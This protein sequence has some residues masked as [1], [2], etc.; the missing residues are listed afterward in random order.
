MR[1]PSDSLTFV[2]LLASALL[3]E[4]GGLGVEAH[5]VTWTPIIDDLDGGPGG[6]CSVCPCELIPEYGEEKN[7]AIT[8]I[9]PYGGSLYLGTYNWD[10]GAEIWRWN[11]GGSFEPVMTG[12]WGK[13]YNQFLHSMIEFEGDLYAGTW[14]DVPSLFPQPERGMSLWRYDGVDWEAVTEDGFGDFENDAA[15]SLTVFQGALYAGAYNP[16]DGPEVWR[17]LDGLAWEP[18]VADQVDADSEGPDENGFCCPMNSDATVVGVFNDRLHVFTESVRDFPQ[19]LTQQDVVRGTQVWATSAQGPPPFNDL[20]QVNESGYGNPCGTLNNNTSWNMNTHLVVH[21]GFLYVG[22]WNWEGDA[23][24]FRTDGVPQ[25]GGATYAWEE[26]SLPGFGHQQLIAQ[27]LAV[28]QDYLFAGTAGPGGTRLWAL[29][30]FETGQPPSSSWIC[31]VANGFGHGA[32]REII[33]AALAVGNTLYLGVGSLPI[34][35][36]DVRPELWALSFD[37]DLDEDCDRFAGGIFADCDDQD[38][39]VNPGMTEIPNNGVDDDCDPTTP[40]VPGS[41]GT[42][43][44][45]PLE[46]PDPAAIWADVNLSLLLTLLAARFAFRRPARGTSRGSG[47]SAWPPCFCLALPRRR[48]QAGRQGFLH[49]GS[50]SR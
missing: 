17:S 36:L 35:L 26:L 50:V 10:K 29:P 23:Q 38:P 21:E 11:P 30:L 18:V 31:V 46:R 25:G 15:T 16:T 7:L 13:A 42:T 39:L 33:P 41:C 34:T 45:A 22:T 20:V 32:D 40:D 37:G 14:I 28:F 47:R 44:R 12:G 19:E 2:V 24:V 49:T 48:D 9:L 4:I 6:F 8:R 3:V 5:G 43:V 1:R 27:P